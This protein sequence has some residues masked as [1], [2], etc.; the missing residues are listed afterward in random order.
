LLVEEGGVK[1]LFDPG[2]FS[3]KEDRVSPYDFTE[4]SA[5]CITHQHVDHVDIGALKIIMANNIHAKLFTNTGV[6]H[7]LAS[8]GIEAEI[9]EEGEK[10]IGG[11]RIEAYSADHEPLLTPVPHNT[12]YIINGT[13]LHPGDSLNVSLHKYAG[14]SVLALPVTAPWAD[15][16][17]IAEFGAAMH[18]KH[19]IPIHDGYVKEFFLSMQYKEF[20]AYVKDYGSMFHSINN[21]GEEVIIE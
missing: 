2:T 20:A 18:P 17:R 10:N 11:V 9:Y 21:P 12:A 19:I 6:A 13:F 14:V 1:I 16:V 7:I 5:V 3:F 15:K 8:E 4:L